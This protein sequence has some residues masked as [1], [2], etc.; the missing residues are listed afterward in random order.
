MTDSPVLLDI[1]PRGVATATLNRPEVGNAAADEAERDVPGGGHDLIGLRDQV[2]A[3]KLPE[4]RRSAPAA[5]GTSGA[6]AGSV[7]P[8]RTGSRGTRAP[9]QVQRG[10]DRGVTGVAGPTWISRRASA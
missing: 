4:V 5:R 3:L 9:R 6:G 10:G 2:H 7:A 1:D 8:T